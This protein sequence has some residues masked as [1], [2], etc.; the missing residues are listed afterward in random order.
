[1]KKRKQMLK[2]INW[3]IVQMDKEEIII[4]QNWEFI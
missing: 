3:V 1:M 4:S 2:W